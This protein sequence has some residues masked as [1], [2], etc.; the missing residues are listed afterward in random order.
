MLVWFQN[1]WHKLVG[2]P[3]HM[4][5]EQRAFH[6]IGVITIAL[7]LFLIPVNIALE[8]RVVSVMLVII[9]IILV[10]LYVRSRIYGKY[11]FSLLFYAGASYLVVTITFLYNSGSQGSAL[12]L[13]LL[14]YLFLIAFTNH[15]FHRVWTL[16]H[17]L[18]P[19]SLLYLEYIA[20]HLIPDIYADVQYRAI[21]I[22][23]TMIVIVICTYGITIYLRSNY[24]RERGKAEQRAL[25]IE[26]QNHE[27]SLQNKLLQ[28]SNSEKIR[29][30]SILAHDLRNPMSAITGVLEILT[31]QKLP[32]D[33][34]RKMKEELLLASRNTSELLDNLLSWTSNQIKGLKPTLTKVHPEHVIANV[35]EIQRFVANKKGITIRTSFEP[36]IEVR[37]DIDM[38]ELVIR[39]LISNALKF[40]PK[41]GS[42]DILV[43][44]DTANSTLTIRDSG[45]GIS[46][47]DLKLLF[48]GDIQSTYGTE[49][50]KG[51]G[52]GLFL[53]K[54]LISLNSGKIGAESTLGEGSVFFVSLPLYQHEELAEPAFSS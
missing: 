52:M 14:T 49:H 47:E 3:E 40:T 33:V 1:F 35:L 50:E 5:A 48:D 23:T 9:A 10:V 15:R 45:I 31:E 54:Q 8:L 32:D 43:R 26:A 36:D 34:Q 11:A 2:N 39:N 13:F 42:I 38:L 18:V 51:F 29:L 17:L 28:Q 25:K 19:T 30:I 20:P 53:S 24:E 12:Y 22:A 6:V 44:K 41:N 4:T 16:L 46:K 37:A 21:D 7:M 27:I